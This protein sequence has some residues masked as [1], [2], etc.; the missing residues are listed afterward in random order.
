[1]TVETAPLDEKTLDRLAEDLGR[2]RAND[3]LRGFAVEAERRMACIEAAASVP[4]LEDLHAECHALKGSAAT[5]GALVVAREV[6]RMVAA[7][8][9]GETEAAI[10]RVAAL[11]DLVDAAVA[12][13]RARVSEAGRPGLDPV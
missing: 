2:A 10:G 5:Y 9:A 12:A 3:L 7:C 6:D 8:R 11:R 4:D 13:C 1:M